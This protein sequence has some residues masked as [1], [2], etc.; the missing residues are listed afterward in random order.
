MSTQE[1]NYLIEQEPLAMLY[2]HAN[3]YCLIS[4]HSVGKHLCGYVGVSRGHILHHQ[5]YSEVY[6]ECFIH[7]GLTFSGDIKMLNLIPNHKDLHWFGFDCAHNG[8]YAPGYD[9]EEGEYCTFE[10][11]KCMVNKMAEDID[12]WTLSSPIKVSE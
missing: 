2:Q 4:R 9:Q 1:I 5:R 10:Y 11:V 7:G 12:N 3:H 6:H 8:D